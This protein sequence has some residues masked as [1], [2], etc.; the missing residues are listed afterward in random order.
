M[1]KPSDINL[2]IFDFDGTLSLSDKAVLRVLKK[3][4]CEMNLDISIGKED[5]INNLGKPCKQF[6]ESILGPSHFYLWKEI[7][8]KY[9]HLIPQF[10]TVLPGV[11]ETLEI[12]KKRNYRLALYSNCNPP[13][14][15]SVLHHLGLK[16]CF[17]YA[18]CNGQNNLTKA[19]LLGKIISKF[20]NSKAA[21]VGDRIHDIE[22]ARENNALSVGVLYGYGK[23]EPKKADITI[24]KFS[25]LLNV[26]RGDLAPCM[27]TKLS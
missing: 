27:Y 4:F 22:A 24:N 9:D 10:E 19:E 18:E 1:I 17:D 26:F 20:S 14:F 12:L 15:D 3:A 16:E 23:N 13:Y 2:L 5:V 7:S 6:Y 11:M 21:V 8:D 25:D